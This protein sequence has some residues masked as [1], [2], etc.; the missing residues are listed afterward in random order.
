MSDASFDFTSRFL[1]A[2]A[3]AAGVPREVLFNRVRNV[4]LRLTQQIDPTVT[5][6]VGAYEAGF[7]LWARDNL[8]KARAMAFEA[9]PYVHAHYKDDVIAKGVDYRNVAVSPTSG[10]VTI[11]V[12]RDFNGGERGRV[13]Q[14]ASLTTNL[15]TENHEAVEVEGVRL[16]DAVDLGAD[17]RLVA[18]ID[19]E[20]ALEQV[21]SGARE[22][23]AR[24][25][26]VFV[27]VE[28]EAMWQGQWLDSDVA[29]WFRGIGLVPI[30]RDFQ[31]WQQYNIV[32]VS[33]ELAR[34]PEVAKLAA[35]VYAAAA[36][37]AP[38]AAAAVVPPPVPTS[39]IGRLQ[40]V[41]QR[42]LKAQNEQLRDQ[43]KRLRKQT[44]RMRRQV[45]GLQKRLAL[46]DENTSV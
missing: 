16:D 17:D 40:G 5:L 46:L 45:G 1:L 2:A 34:D 25:S 11:H 44:R 27:E 4:V 15:K 31:R 8:P 26:L 41:L 9:N 6:E 19:V 22:T 28:S 39:K 12:P 32:F 21:L 24:A 37:P 7:S 43:N 13:N 29:A 23:L 18:W 14:M 33:Q 35:M 36:K 10:P 42:T 20:G 38:A 3:D 30:L